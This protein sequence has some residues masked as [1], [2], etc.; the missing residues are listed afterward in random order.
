M[1]TKT[2]P[3][4]KPRTPIT[5]CEYDKKAAQY[6]A[7]PEG[8]RFRKVGEKYNEKTDFI[9][10]FVKEWKADAGIS[11]IADNN[12]PCITPSK[13][14]SRGRFVGVKP[15]PEVGP[16]ILK[17]LGHRDINSDYLVECAASLKKL[18]ADPVNNRTSVMA[19]NWGDSPQGAQYWNARHN[20]REPISAADLLYIKA[21]IAAYENR[22]AELR[23]K[24]KPPAL[25]PTVA[26]L[27]AKISS[28]EAENAALKAKIAGAKVTFPS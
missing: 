17:W 22:I 11:K 16:N 20:G 10:W 7:P 25:E 5:E 3:A 23:G 8:Y 6:G 15:L 9:A 21:T 24:V 19:L 4:F 13:R 2:P 18:V 12:H 1:N 28:L 26:D 14:D 27:K